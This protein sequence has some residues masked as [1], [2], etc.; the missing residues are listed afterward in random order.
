MKRLWDSCFLF[1]TRGRWRSGWVEEG[2]ELAVTEAPETGWQRYGPLGAEARHLHRRL[3]RLL[4]LAVNPG[5]GWV[6]LPASWAQGKAAERV[7]IQCG[8]LAGEA[9]GALAALF[10][11]A[12]DGFGVWLGSKLTGRTHPFERAVIEGELEAV[13]EFGAREEKKGGKR[14]QLALL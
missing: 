2:L 11:Q 7:M 5:R 14:L 4:W 9:A 8:V 13:K 12:G 3:A 1:P 6:E 10:W